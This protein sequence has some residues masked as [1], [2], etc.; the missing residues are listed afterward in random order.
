MTAQ[1]TLQCLPVNNPKH[2]TAKL[3]NCQSTVGEIMLSQHTIKEPAEAQNDGRG[4]VRLLW[5]LSLQ[6]LVEH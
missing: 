5:F 1:A 4:E 2:I 6:A 3:F